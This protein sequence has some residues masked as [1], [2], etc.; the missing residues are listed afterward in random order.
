MYERYRP[1]ILVSPALLVIL[2]LF[3]GGLIFGLARSFN[4][5][6]LIGLNDPNLD[7][8]LLSFR[9]GRATQLLHQPGS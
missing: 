5:F 6:P 3:I 7:A 9:C 2:V 8:Y 4:Y 1:Y